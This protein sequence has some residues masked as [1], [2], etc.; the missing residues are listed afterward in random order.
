MMS[1]GAQAHADQKRL[2][3][4]SLLLLGYSL[5]LFFLTQ[6]RVRYEWLS[7]PVELSVPLEELNS[8]LVFALIH[9]PL[10][11]GFLNSVRDGPDPSQ[12]FLLLLGF[13]LNLCHGHDHLLMLFV[14]H[15]S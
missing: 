11:Y 13:T 7:S 12:K 14:P 6:D 4:P 9:V 10:E 8:V 3:C 15:L 5:F 2:L 1:N